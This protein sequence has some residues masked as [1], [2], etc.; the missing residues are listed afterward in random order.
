MSTWNNE[1]SEKILMGYKTQSIACF[2]SQYFMFL[3]MNTGIV[4]L[5]FPLIY[6]IVCKSLV[7]KKNSRLKTK[8]LHFWRVPPE[9]YFQDWKCSEC[10]PILKMVPQSINWKHCLCQHLPAF[11]GAGG[12]SGWAVVP[13]SASFW[14]CSSAKASLRK[15]CRERSPHHARAGGK[16]T[17]VIQSRSPQGWKLSWVKPP[18]I[19]PRFYL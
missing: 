5:D 4:L 11:L 2:I 16:T 6:K 7:N 3:K 8:C 19:L 1:I 15:G 18:I 13:L 17:R 10:K 9:I 14:P 12:A